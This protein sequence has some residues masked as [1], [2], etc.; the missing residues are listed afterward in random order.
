MGQTVSLTYMSPQIQNVCVKSWKFL[1]C[2]L[3]KSGQSKY[4]ATVVK[5]LFSFEEELRRT[6]FSSID[7]VI[8]EI[9]E[10]F[11]QLKNLAENMTF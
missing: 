4:L 3:C 7:K 8:A 1:L 11:Q 5:V 10:R 6:I 2:H 9:H